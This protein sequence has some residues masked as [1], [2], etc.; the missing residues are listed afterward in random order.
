[1]PMYTE[2]VEISIRIIAFGLE[3]I[4]F[5]KEIGNYILRAFIILHLQSSVLVI[6]DSQL[7]CYQNIFLFSKQIVNY[8]Q[9]MKYIKK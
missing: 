8:F 4:A 7:E 3:F 5:E 2:F 9:T 1:M 6:L